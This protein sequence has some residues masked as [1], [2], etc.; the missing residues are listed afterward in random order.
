VKVALRA[1][2]ES[3]TASARH[4]GDTA[5]DIKAASLLVDGDVTPFDVHVEVVRLALTL[6]RAHALL[7]GEPVEDVI[8]QAA[9]SL[10]AG[11]DLR[12]DQ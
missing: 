10:A 8:D 6:A 5:V 3:L 1:A 11:D 9:R 7:L 12:G 4:D 2:T